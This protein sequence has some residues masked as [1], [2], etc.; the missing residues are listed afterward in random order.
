MDIN[1]KSDIVNGNFSVACE[2]LSIQTKTQTI[3]LATL[4]E[5]VTFGGNVYKCASVS[6]GVPGFARGGVRQALGLEV[7]NTSVEIMHGMDCKINGL[8]WAHLVAGGFF[9]EAK[10][11]LSRLFLLGGTRWAGDA[12]FSGVAGEITGTPI[13][14]KFKVDSITRVFDKKFPIHI[15]EEKCQRV[16]GMCGFNINSVTIN[17]TAQTTSDRSIIYISDP[18]RSDNFYAG[19]SAE[20]T[21]PGG[22]VA[23]RPIGLSGETFLHLSIPL[24]W[25]S[26]GLSVKAIPACQRTKSACE[27]WGNVQNYL[28]MPFVPLPE[29]A[30]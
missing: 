26:E 24:P 16:F 5:D 19:G 7:Q 11:V 27:S 30:R 21:G 2:I 12:F 6:G 20:V 9:N 28:G 4:D 23:R 1:D 3:R 10:F 8:P 13:S 29:A 22:I 18:G 25:R 15:I 17:K 14:T